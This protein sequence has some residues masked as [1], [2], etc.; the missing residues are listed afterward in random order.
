MEASPRIARGTLEPLWTLTL[1]P[2]NIFALDGAE[3]YVFYD[4]PD[5]KA[6][7]VEVRVAATGVI[8]RGQPTAWQW[9]CGLPVFTQEHVVIPCFAKG[10]LRMTKDLSQSTVLWPVGNGVCNA[11]GDGEWLYGT[12]WEPKSGGTLAKISLAT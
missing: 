4:S 11:T 5:G 1:A 3:L 7:R 9:V 8:L 12:C 10:V 2:F 6:S